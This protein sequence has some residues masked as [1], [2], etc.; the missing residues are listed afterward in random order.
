M[1]RTASKK[2]GWLAPSV[3]H[4]IDSH[5]KIV[6]EVHKLLPISSVIIETASFDIQKIKNPQISGEEYQQGEQLNFWNVR[7]YV[8]WHD[9]HECQHCHG[10]LKDKI[11]TVHHKESRKIGGDAPNNLITLCET[12]HN[13]YHAGKL[14]LQ[15]T[16]G[17]SFRDATFMGIMRWAVYN[18]LKEVYPHVSITYGYITKNNRITHGI[19]K[20]HSADAF[21]ITGNLNF[22]KGGKKKLNQSPYEV[23]GY[24]LFDKVLYQGIEC[25]IF[26]RRATGYF[27]LRKLDG[28]VI[29]RSA[30]YK[31][32]KLL[33]RQKTLLIERKAV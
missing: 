17:A 8:L 19:D 27:D 5:L 1:N 22:L 7:E 31:N 4:K 33:E 32:L 26:G 23:K 6:A 29:H 11:L 15:F 24:R 14:K 9:N 12:C 30:S 2:E 16:R 21:C 10:K 28:T 13:Q 20:T 18:K 25:F 3:Q